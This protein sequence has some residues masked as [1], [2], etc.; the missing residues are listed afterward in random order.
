MLVRSYFFRLGSARISMNI[1]GAPRMYVHLEEGKF[2][3]ILIESTIFNSKGFVI[4][5][6]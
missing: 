3:K 2:S 1:V 5:Y 4:E 6:C